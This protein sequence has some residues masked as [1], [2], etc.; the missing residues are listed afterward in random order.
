MYKKIELIRALE[1]CPVVEYNINRLINADSD[2]ALIKKV[3]NSKWVSLLREQ[4]Y[5]DGSYGRFHSMNSRLKQ[6]FPTTEIAVNCMNY[7]G[8]IRG[9]DVVDKCCDYMETLLTDLSR[10]PDCVEKNIWFKPAMPLFISAKLS[11]FSSDNK[12]YKEYCRIYLDILKEA[13]VGGEYN[14]KRV[15]D[16]SA[17][18][19]GCDIHGR[20]LGL[21]SIYP[22]ELYSNIQDQIDDSLQDAYL[23]WLRIQPEPVFYTAANL[24]AKDAGKITD[25]YYLYHKLSKFRRFKTVYKDHLSW[26]ESLEGEDGLW[27]FG[28]RFKIQKLSDDWR[29]INRRTADHSV[30]ILML[31]R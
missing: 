9:F 25:L 20:Y 24:S 22:I 7:L 6:V 30:Y 15:N 2:E 13:F 3:G 17:D 29:L 28:S 4:Q 16:I 12:K 18:L 27:D 10:W 31:L 21:Y 5:K 1:P 11:N 14:V 8:L 23:Q 19:L 26:L